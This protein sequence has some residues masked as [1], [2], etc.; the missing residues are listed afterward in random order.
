MTIDDAFVPRSTDGNA[1]SE[2]RGQAVHA[3]DGLNCMCDC[4]HKT[5]QFIKF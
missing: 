2:S 3:S 1:I 4:I 5:L